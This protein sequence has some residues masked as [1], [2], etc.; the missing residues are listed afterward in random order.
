MINISYEFVWRLTQILD[1]K[2][3]NF[4]VQ[5]DKEDKFEFKFNPE[6]EQ[7]SINF[8]LEGNLNNEK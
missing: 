5:F 1:N 8:K 6:I 7:A 3:A 4:F 2:T